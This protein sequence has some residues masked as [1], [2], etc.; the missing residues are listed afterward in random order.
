MA[1]TKRA[2]PAAAPPPAPKR[3]RAAKSK[4]QQ[5][6]EEDEDEEVLEEEEEDED[7][8]EDE[9]D[10]DDDEEDEEVELEEDEDA[11]AQ[12]VRR[13]K[14]GQE[15]FSK[16]YKPPTHEEL[17]RLKETEELFQS[18]ILRMEVRRPATRERE[19]ERKGGGG[20][21][22]EGGRETAG[23]LA[24]VLNFTLALVLSHT[25]ESHPRSSVLAL[26]PRSRV[27]A[28]VSASSPP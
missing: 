18:N 12:A 7:H 2:A 17:Q 8:V 20:R 5:E 13:R 11:V 25:P 26:V 21:E 22:R 1:P 19:G 14:L 3:S 27:H 16:Y 10:E 23:V 9:D 6:K 28:L 24:R 4:Q 15:S